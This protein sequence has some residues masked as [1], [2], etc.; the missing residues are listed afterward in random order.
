MIKRAGH[1][2]GIT[3]CSY[4]Q[5]TFQQHNSSSGSF[6]YVIIQVTKI[7]SLLASR[8][9]LP[10]KSR[11]YVW[12][13]ERCGCLE[14]AVSPKG[15]H[16]PRPSSS[17]TS[18]SAS[19]TAGPKGQLVTGSST[20]R[21]RSLHCC[22]QNQNRVLSLLGKNHSVCSKRGKIIAEHSQVLPHSPWEVPLLLCHS[23]IPVAL[24]SWTKNTHWKAINHTVWL[25]TKKI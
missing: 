18:C 22:K 3:L 10:H 4:Y 21:P 24:M 11:F 16:C 2:T 9:C 14:R 20:M 19:G 23:T 25:E 6:S 13:S 15:W 8:T 12:Q 5:N 17:R 1:C 7:L